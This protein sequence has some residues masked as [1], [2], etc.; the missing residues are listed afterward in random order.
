MSD[1]F[2][3]V[4]VISAWGRGVRGRHGDRVK[5]YNAHP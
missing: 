5:S 1:D 2:V 3:A 4:L